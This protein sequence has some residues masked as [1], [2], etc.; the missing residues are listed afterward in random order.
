MGSARLLH[1]PRRCRSRPGPGPRRRRDGRP[2]LVL[3]QSGSGSERRGDMVRA[4]PRPPRRSASARAR[5]TRRPE[6]SSARATPRCRSRPEG[7]VPADAAGRS[8]STASNRP[9]AR[10]R[11][12]DRF[13]RPAAARRAIGLATQGS[14]GMGAIC[15]AADDPYR[16]E[17]AVPADAAG[18]RLLC[19][20]LAPVCNAVVVQR[21][22]VRSVCGHASARRDRLVVVWGGP[23][24]P[25]ADREGVARRRRRQGRSSGWALHLDCAGGGRGYAAIRGWA[26]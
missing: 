21:R 13:A 18:R 24:R 2:R 14:S 8:H 10:P 16:P 17:G 19:Q 7:A 26:D 6:Q 15:G 5:T 3:R 9:A 1:P 20:V 22:V 23:V 11:P 12:D 25:R 4:Q